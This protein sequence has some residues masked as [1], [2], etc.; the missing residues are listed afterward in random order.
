MQK[1]PFPL[2]RR[3]ERAVI[4]VSGPDARDFLQNLVT[5]DI[6]GL[7]EGKAA[8]AAL[9]QPQG[10]VLF[11][12][13][14]VNLGERYAIDC[15]AA[16]RDELLKKL[17]HYK[18][19]AKVT[20]EA[21]DEDVGVA[22]MRPDSGIVYADPRA[23]QLGLRVIA[24]KGSLPAETE[25]PYRGARIRLGLGDSDADLGSGELF[26]HEANLDQLG[27]VGMSKGCYIGQ[28]VV[29]R[30]E[31]R[32]TARNRILPVYISG[33]APAKGSEIKANGKTVG[34]LLSSDGSDA[35]ALIRLDRLKDAVEANDALLTEGKPLRVRKPHWVRYEVA[36]PP[37]E[38]D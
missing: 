24:P 6:A 37:E 22:F 21:S 29:S 2:H 15:S 8:Y 9:L 34:T 16:Q 14:I 36:L 27:A 28:E 17:N 10:K 1:L 38:E 18:L 7:A 32:G 19:R 23:A 5:A 13:F 31:H 26:P 35:L 33:G 12:F 3:A 11:D 20:I 25:N 4:S 30:M